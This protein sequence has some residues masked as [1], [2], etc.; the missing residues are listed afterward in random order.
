[1]E[2]AFLFPGQGAQFP[3][4]A[5][6]LYEASAA[7]RDLFAEASE[8]TG[9]DLRRLLFEG[10]ADELRQTDKTQIAISTASLAALIYLRECGVESAR[11][12]GFSLGE[13]VALH[14]AGVIDRSALYALVTPRGEISERVSRTLDDEAG[15]AGMAAAIGMDLPEVRGVLDALGRSDVYPALYNTPKQVVIGGTFAGLAAATEALKAAGIGRVVPLAVSGPFHTPLMEPAREEF[16]A[17]AAG[18]AFSDP[19]KPVYTN[20]TGGQVR[21]GAEA[22]DRCLEQ[23]VSTVMWSTEV[24]TLDA[25]GVELLLEVGPGSVLR[26]HWK[27]GAQAGGGWDIDRCRGAGTRDEIETIAKELTVH[28]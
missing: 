4:M 12:A 17:I 18:V 22:R 23:L 19:T 1:M 21:T 2:I 3:G 20:V 9:Q 25:D 6:D 14:D 10:D 26:G 8:L 11:S 13:Y 15:R 16:G 5:S 24:R 7:V 27:A 28:A